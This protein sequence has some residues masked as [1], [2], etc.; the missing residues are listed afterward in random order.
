MPDLQVI[1]RN[2]IVYGDCWPVVNTVQSVVRA[3][4]PECRGR[5]PAGSASVPDTDAGGD[6]NT[7]SAATGA[8][9]PVLCPETGTTVPPGT[10]YQR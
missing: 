7:V 6:I 10:G 4:Q 9:L 1:C 2:A 8:Y 5:L 3:I